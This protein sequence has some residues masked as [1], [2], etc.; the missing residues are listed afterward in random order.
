MDCRSVYFDL[1]KDQLEVDAL[2]PAMMELCNQSFLNWDD[3]RDVNSAGQWHSLGLEVG[4]AQGV[5]GT[6]VPSGVLEQSPGGGLG[7][8]PPEAKYAYTICSGQTI[9]L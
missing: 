9:F 7:A 2:E 6:E 3:S 4:W 8:K 1:E 5:W